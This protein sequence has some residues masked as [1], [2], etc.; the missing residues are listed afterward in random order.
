FFCCTCRVIVLEAQRLQVQP[1]VTGYLGLDVTLLCQFIQGPEE[2]DISQVQ[3]NLLPPEGK[4]ITIAVFK[5]QTEVL[6]FESPLKERVEISEQ[7]LII[8]NVE[9]SDAGLYTC[10]VTTFPIGLFEKSTNLIVQ[11]EYSNKK[12]KITQT[13]LF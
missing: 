3:W 5:S 13:L 12:L 8:R 4:K 2:A 6:L 7:S 1:E 9:M 11:G 10:T